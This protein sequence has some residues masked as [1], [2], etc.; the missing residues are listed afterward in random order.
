MSRPTRP[1]ELES[2]PVCSSS[3]S[4]FSFFTKYNDGQGT[5]NLSLSR[6]EAHPQGGR[7]EHV[8]EKIPQD[9]RRRGRRA[10][11]RRRCACSR[12]D[13]LVP[14]GQRARRRRRFIGPSRPRRL[15]AACRCFLSRCQED[16]GC[17]AFRG[18]GSSSGVG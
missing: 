17:E 10:S 9:G 2:K 16:Q 3:S 12:T 4:H 5:N 7:Q 6:A 13:Q 8:A 14:L 18:G 11:C 1:T 15:K